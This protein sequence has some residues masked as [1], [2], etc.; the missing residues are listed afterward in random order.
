MSILLYDARQ[1][2]VLGGGGGLEEKLKVDRRIGG[3]ICGIHEYEQ[4]NTYDYCTPHCALNI[5]ARF[6]ILMMTKYNCRN[7]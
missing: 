5:G 1:S 7:F 4:E 2:V 3:L 6:L